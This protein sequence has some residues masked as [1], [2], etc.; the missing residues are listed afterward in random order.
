MSISRR[1]AR[2]L[3]S[4]IFFVGS[5]G[6]LKNPAGPAEVARPLTDPLLERLHQAGVPASVDGALLVR[7][8]AGVQVAG[9]VALVTGRFPRLGAAVLAASLVPTTLAG[10]AFWKESDPDRRR[11]QQLQFAKNLSILGGLVIAS[12]DTDGK[13]GKAWLA[14][15]TAQ[16][17]VRRA[18]RA[19]ATARL[20]AKI[21]QLEAA[22]A[23]D[24]LAETLTTAAST[25]SARSHSAAEQI[26]ETLSAV[27]HAV[28]EQVSNADLKTRGQA[29]AD[30]VAEK[31]A[32]AD[33]PSRGKHVADTVADKVSSAASAA[34]QLTA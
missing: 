2:P 10:H 27:G 25:L 13:P 18:E 19:A 21:A 32:A 28:A 6:T 33:L 1:V 22:G 16:E 4:S 20:E 26:G 15:A 12:L 30:T 24:T 7:I 29:V 14:K 31:V 3:L 8:N 9:G 11:T 23:G 5:V 17:L 34:K